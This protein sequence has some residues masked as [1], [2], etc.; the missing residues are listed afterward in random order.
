MNSAVATMKLTISGTASADS[1]LRIL[2]FGNDAAC[3]FQIAHPWP[4]HEAERDDARTI[5]RGLRCL[6]LVVVGRRLHRRNLHFKQ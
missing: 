3:R 4:H 6:Q 2:R 5:L 1:F